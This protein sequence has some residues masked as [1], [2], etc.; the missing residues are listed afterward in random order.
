[1]ASR[2]AVLDDYQ[3]TARRSAD[4]SALD[5]RATVDFFHDQVSDEDV[6]VERLAPYDVVLAM[7]ERTAFPHQ[8]LDRL[9]AL[10]L[11]VTTGMRNASIDVAAAQARGVVVCGTRSDARS[12]VEHTWALI[13]GLSRHLAEEHRAM[14]SGGWQSTVGSGL[15]GKTLGVIGLGRIG[16][17]VAAIGRAF[18]MDVVAWSE[19]L[20]DEVAVERGATRVTYDEL[21]G[22]ADVITVHQVLSGR[23]R[24]SWAHDS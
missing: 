18:G 17:Q 23:T 5:G 12:T 7:R 15:H 11:L 4:W 10:R 14:A 19:N 2:V 20:S 6:L 3:D 9:P 22:R 21:L 24:G 1:M 16:A 8:V 13:L